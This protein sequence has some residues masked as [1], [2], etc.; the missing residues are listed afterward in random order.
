MSGLRDRLRRL[1]KTGQSDATQ[2]A[3]TEVRSGSVI[4][5]G[6][7]A[8]REAAEWARLAAEIVYT[9]EGSF[10]RRIR[11]FPLTERHGQFQ[12]AELHQIDQHLAELGSPYREL[13][14]PQHLLFFDTET[15]GLGVGTGNV[16]FMIGYGYLQDDSFVVEQ[17]FIRNPAEEYGALSYL[18]GLLDRYSHIITY[19][20]RS[21]DWPVLMNRFVLERLPAPQDLAQIDLLYPARSIWRDSLPS[22]RLGVVEEMKLG[23]HRG[24]DLPGSEAPVRYVQYLSSRRVEDVEEIFLHNER[25]I[26]S[27]AGL[28]VLFQQL[29]SGTSR[30]ANRVVA[31]DGIKVAIW[32]DKHGHRTRARETLIAALHQETIT[33]SQLLEAA[34]LWKRWRE[35]D[36]AAV[37]W[38]IYCR[39]SAGTLHAVEPMIELA[40]YYEHRVRD[41]ES[42]L[43]WA[44]RA[45]ELLLRRLSL[46]R[47]SASDR[48]V[49][50]QIDHRIAR[51]RR[52]IDKPAQE[53]LQFR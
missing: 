49:L 13:P 27:L 53:M 35:Y 20:G 5:G 19:N 52:K 32:L 12:L 38:K 39:K 1:T 48:E 11:K 2:P 6:S 26:C 40:I 28:T 25:D 42:A 21:F 34:A 37:L 29:I 23:Y 44:D 18:R 17:L 24:P 9:P 47:R 43:M 8:E 51:L 50:R 31:E 7:E 30:A 46:S 4:A 45:R 33:R 14:S 15:T 22:C 10:I 41:V 36:R 3:E 16:P